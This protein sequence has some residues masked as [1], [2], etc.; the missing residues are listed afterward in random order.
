MAR[1]I[2]QSSSI[3]TYDFLSG[4]AQNSPP[5]P[6]TRHPLREAPS[7][8]QSTSTSMPPPP[9]LPPS[10]T[11]TNKADPQ[12]ENLR[13]Q[14]HTL[15]YELDA[16]K[17]D[18][19]L[20]LLHHEAALRDAQTRSESDFARAQ[21]AEA[22]QA[23]ATKK[24]EQWSRDHQEWQNVSANEKLALEKKV[25][26]LQ[27]DSRALR[28]ELEDVRGE[29]SM[30]ERRAGH[31][32]GELEAQFVAVKGSVEGVQV[33]LEGKVA[34]LQA[35]QQRLVKEEARAGELEN[36][37]LRLKA[38]TGDA[39]TLG[40]IKKELSE[41]VA[42]ISRLEAANRE[43]S[44]ELKSMRK[45][46][47]K[48]EVVLEEKL[49]LEAKV[50]MMEDLRREL[51]EAQLQKRILEDEKSGWT[52]YLQ[53]EARAE[54][55]MSFETPE[56]M[57][58]AFLQ[59]RL[60]RLSLLDR[61]GTIQPELS[62]K[63]ENIQTLEEEK[64]KLRAELEEARKNSLANGASSTNTTTAAAAPPADLKA[65]ARLER[66][67]NLMA[68][69]VQYLREQ[70]KTFEA[71]E[72][73]FN[74][75]NADE[76][77]SQR[78]NEL[79]GL[80]EQYRTEM[81]SL[82]TE[83]SKIEAPAPAVQSPQKRQREDEG[84]AEERMGEMRR[85][86]RTLQSDI[87]K[88]QTRNQVLE[89]ELKASLSQVE[90]LKASSRTRTLELRD[91][92]TAQAEAIKMVTLRTLREENQALLEQLE[93]RPVSTKVV[94]ISTLENVRLQLDEA[95]SQ[96]KQTEKKT[97]RLKQIWGSKSLEFREAVCSILGWKLDF[98]PNGRVK[99]TSIL[100]PT[101]LNS[102]GEEEENSIVFDGENGTMK[103][104]GGPKSLFAGEIKGLIEFWV[105]GRK[106][107]PCFLAACT[108][109]FYDRTT[110]AA[111]M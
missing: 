7:N 20:S 34:A 84:E 35:T 41:Q 105:E 32:Y 46:Q 64:A 95:Q 97:L 16:L 30:Q 50:R 48:V 13:S 77:R 33:D 78:I 61:I 29:L 107:I 101:L 96:I 81:Q 24:L 88:L 66:Q 93:N 94:P 92:P 53:N 37:V 5:G 67:K 25:R 83:M 52:S 14:L 10:A 54:E 49:A 86:A 103:V 51:S 3:P 71:E 63:E 15:Q 21:A 6:S 62:V 89:A 11:S 9:A 100:Y 42:Y 70:M 106:E 75:E 26:G 8:R 31:A 79:E 40:L 4:N 102:S 58:R 72:A 18:R 69:E 57:A 12:T 65:R 43:Q 90:T 19:E 111:R 56:Q 55:D 99:A 98:M 45:A 74:P 91:N 44:A 110:R 2:H 36:E 27:E 73:E 47:K 87:D 85:K 60:E 80:V 68:K 38:Q 109:E 23:A 59:E 82:H 17:Q 28:E 104:S 22:A 39:E 1:N 76:E 108:L